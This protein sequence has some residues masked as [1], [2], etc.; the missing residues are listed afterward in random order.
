MNQIVP[1]TNSPN[2]NLVVPLSVDGL[3]QDMFLTLR[4]NETAN[5]WV[6]T[7]KNS[8]NQ[9]ILDSVPF[10]TGNAPAGNILAQFAYLGIGSAYIINAGAVPTP[11]YP[12][13]K[14]LGNDFVLL[15][16]DT[17]TPSGSR[18]ASSSL[19]GVSSI[20]AVNVFTDV[21]RKTTP[22]RMSFT[23]GES[24]TLRITA[25]LEDSGIVVE[26]DSVIFL[27]LVGA[28]FL[29]GSL[30]F[31]SAVSGNQ[32]SGL[33]SLRAPNYGPAGDTGFVSIL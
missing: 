21:R 19:V 4:F 22:T 18:N 26:G 13:A 15:W 12:N 5:Y 6:M 33:V 1:L 31:V 10:V 20:Q 23:P 24:G 3:I 27:N 14:D 9:L 30:M 7:I 2:Q 17:P 32:I 28:S 16:G 29:N 25:I 11:D 8:Q